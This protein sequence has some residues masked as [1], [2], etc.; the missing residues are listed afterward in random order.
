M[1]YCFNNFSGL[2]FAAISC[3]SCKAFFRR[4]ALSD[5]KFVC[6][7][8]S[9]QSCE[10]TTV[11]RRFCQYHR[12]Q[13]CF[14]V[15]MKKEYIMSEE[16]KELKRKKIEQNR[17]KRKFNNQTTDS[18]DSDKIYECKK[19]IKT[20][21]CNID[22][23]PN[24]STSES[25]SLNSP[26]E[27]ES[28]INVAEIVERI[29]SLEDKSATY[30]SSLMKTQ[31]EALSIMSEIIKCPDNALKLISHF[32]T[33]PSD[34]VLILSKIMNSPFDTLTVFT[35]FM[36]SPTDALQIIQKILSK[37]NEVL[38]FLQNLQKFPEDALEIMNKFLNSPVEA[39][40]ILSKMMN[41]S[42][43][44]SLLPLSADSTKNLCEDDIFKSMLSVNSTNFSNDEDSQSFGNLNTPPSTSYDTN[45]NDSEDKK[46][47]LDIANEVMAD[48]KTVNSTAST[49]A[50]R[51]TLDS[52][53]S[54]AISLEFSSRPMTSS[55]LKTVTR[56]LNEIEQGK[57]NELNNSNKALYAPVDDDLSNNFIFED[58]KMKASS[59]Q[60]LPEPQL[61]KVI[62]LTAIAIRRLIKMSK[63]ICAFKNLCIEDQIALLKGGCTEMMI[64]RSIMNYDGA[65]WKV[66]SLN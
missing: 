61:L 18:A 33:Y 14:E 53:I 58:Y 13:K 46:S 19:Q 9:E 23:D 65:G 8:N 51:H 54:E 17:V 39:I 20:E 2:N 35:Q 48:V 12:L 41:H 29:V 15:G 63:K 47:L 25:L 45:N 57:L 44:A 34:A 42:N 55:S 7:F 40:Q 11:T 6:P 31:E 49:Q 22:F 64:L 24:T 21:K 16:D 28:S 66:V 37:P 50:E 3:E 4:N 38:T 60:N 10:I 26:M 32:I 30:I 27:M 36:R 43:L 1:S 5:K 59:D 56:E 52:I 62:N